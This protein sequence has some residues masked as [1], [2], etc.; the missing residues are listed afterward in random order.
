MVISMKLKQSAMCIMGLMGLMLAHSCGHLSHKA[1]GQDPACDARSSISTNI[2]LKPQQ[3]PQFISVSPVYYGEFFTNAKGGKST[4]DATQYAGL[5]DLG[6][7]FDLARWNPENSSSL[8]FLIQNTHGRGLTEDFIGDTQV[9]SNIDSF[10][11][12]IQIGEYWW[13]SQWAN[14]V[15]TLRLGKQDLNNEFQRID[16]AQFF[17]QS[18]YGLSPSTAFPTYPHQAAGAVALIQLQD[19]LTWKVGAWNAFVNDGLWGFSDNGSFLVVSELEATYALFQASHPGTIAVGALYE[20][21]GQLNGEAVAAVREYYIQAEQV[22]YKRHPADDASNQ[23]LAVFAGYYPRYPG[24]QPIAKSIG[25]SAVAGLTYTGLL[26]NRQHDVVGLGIAWS[27]LFQGGTNQESATEL[28]YRAQW[29]SKLS[30]QPDLQYIS[31]PSGI[32]RDALA[33]GMRMEIRH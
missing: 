24:E 2:D 20:S 10:D 4:N 13:E 17:I 26:S 18:T 6:V 1:Q 27:E 28:F 14:Q 31:S 7:N 19:Y 16:Q 15:I 30:I 23:G 12:V 22:L 11:N 25:D 21:D 32:Y 5:F 8:H 29:S 9:I 33:I 3:P